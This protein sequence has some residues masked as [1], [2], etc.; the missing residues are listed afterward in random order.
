[1]LWGA[2]DRVQARMHAVDSPT[3]AQLRMRW[4]ASTRA[5]LGVER[6]DAAHTAGATMPLDD[7]LASLT[8]PQ[9]QSPTPAAR[10]TRPKCDPQRPTAGGSK[11]A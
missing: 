3:N 8:A 4:E 9:T 2:G 10:E 6:W 1:M 11:T 5:A 7:A